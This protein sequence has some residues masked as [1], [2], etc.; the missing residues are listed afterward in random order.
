PPALFVRSPLRRRT[1]RRRARR[2][3]DEG[4]GPQDDGDEA[5]GSGSRRI[6]G[7]AWGRRRRANRNQRAIASQRLHADDRGDGGVRTEVRGA[8]RADRLEICGLIVDDVDGE[9]RKV[10]DRRARTLQ[11]RAEICER[12]LGLRAQIGAGELPRTVHAELTRDVDGSSN[13]HRRRTN[14]RRRHARPCGEGGLDL[15]RAFWG[16]GELPAEAR[17]VPSQLV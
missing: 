10:A 15:G 3:P 7:L 13:S 6:T 8:G 14:R 11:Y 16:R 9:R 17:F 12:A 2:S 5:A 4:G 1:A